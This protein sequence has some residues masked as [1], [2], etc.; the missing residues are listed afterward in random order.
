M[1]KNRQNP[2]TN[3]LNWQGKGVSAR[4]QTALSCIIQP[5]HMVSFVSQPLGASFLKGVYESRPIIHRYVQT[6]DGKVV[7]QFLA[8]LYPPSKLTLKELTLK[9]VMLVSLVSGQWGQFIHLLDIL[10]C[11]TQTETTWQLCSFLVTHNVKQ[12]K[13]GTKQ[14]ANKID[15]YSLQHSCSFYICCQTKCSPGCPVPIFFLFFPIFWAYSYFL[16][17][18][19]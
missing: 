15:A 6:R 2:G 13:T 10:Y 7:L 5:K 19:N 9:L 11:M 14:Y 4:T 3:P 8:N 17:F 12:S 1:P 16:L 18:F